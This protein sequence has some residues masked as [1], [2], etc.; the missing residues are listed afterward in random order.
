MKVPFV[1]LE[2][3]YRAIQPAIEKAWHDSFHGFRYIG[4]R[5]ITSFEE[6][7]GKLV[8]ARHCVAT[9]NGTSSL[10]LALKALGVGA[11]HEVITPAFSW[12][13][14][15][16]T[17][18]F[19]NATP[20]FAD[21]DPAT[22]TIDPDQVERAITVRTKAIIVV[23]LYGQPAHI[24]RLRSICN[25]RGLF[26]IEDC[27]QA[28]LTLENG[29]A[30]GTFGHAGA[31]SFYPTKN[32]GAYG[33]AGC[34]VTKSAQ[35]AT[36][37]RRLANHGALQKDDHELE[38]M[39]SRMDVIQAAFLKAKLPYLKRWNRLRRA[40]ATLYNELLRGVEEIVL[41]TERPGATH[42]FHLYV[43]RAKKRDQLKEYLYKHGIQ[44][45]IHYPKAL[46]NTRAYAYLGLDRSL[47][48]V[49]NALE[50][51]VLSLPIYPELTGAQVRYVSQNIKDF[52]KKVK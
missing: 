11:G 39:N 19:C 46:T 31:F 40:H 27:A 33:D 38:G 26:L 24:T 17:I 32:L 35:L 43:I 13:S 12:I 9:S 2:A 8:G 10:I 28:H 37:V 51:E 25:K 30:V 5:Y 41:P 44:T 1:D 42:T 15:A 29:K 34:M 18:S 49:A 36:R 47:F 3:Q 45:L 22:Y 48:P 7:F 16:E 50:K 14:S 20:V 4:G 6:R 23:H 52:Y 21:V